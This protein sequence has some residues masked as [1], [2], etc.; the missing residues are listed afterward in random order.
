MMASIDWSGAGWASAGVLLAGLLSAALYARKRRPLNAALALLAAAALAAMLAGPTQPAASA[1]AIAIATDAPGDALSRALLAVPQ[2]GSITLTGHGLRA[3]Q[4][5]DLPAR[6][7][8][9]TAPQGD[10]LRLDFPRTLPVGR[11]FRL[12]AQHTASQPGWRLQPLAE[13]GQLLA[14]SARSAAAG[15]LTLSWQPP[16]AEQLLLQAR[17]LDAGGKAVAQGPVPL[18]V[19]PPVPLQI[20]GRFGAPSFDAR[21]LNQLL[22]DSRAA[23]DWQTTLGKGL[24][25]AEAARTGLT[26]PNAQIIDAAWFEAQPARR[27]PRCWRRLG[28]ACHSLSWPA[29][30]AMPPSGSANWPYACCP[31]PRPPKRKTSAS[32]ASAASSVPCRPP[33]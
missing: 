26:E 17:L 8:R 14:E 12:T 16:L 18:Q 9:W 32:S 15:P 6:P 1:G 31:S 20:I 7:L 3:A 5:D 22:T 28:K 25:R 21:A 19:T 27:A 4:W 10:L 29:M 23:L 2:A 30:Q 13:N 33:R 11:S 24:S